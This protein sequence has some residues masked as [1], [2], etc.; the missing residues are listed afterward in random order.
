MYACEQQMCAVAA[1][2]GNSAATASASRA[3]SGHGVR[4]FHPDQHVRALVLDGLERANGPAEREP[5]PGVPGAHLPAPPGAAGLL[6]GQR[7][8][9]QI[10]HPGSS[11]GPLAFGTDED[12]GHLVE[13]QDRHRPGGIKRGNLCD[14]VRAFL[15]RQPGLRR[16]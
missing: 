10:E 13:G 11:A 6:G 4:E 8:A 3:A 1:A 12:R 14:R 16:M 15:I 2:T 7:H 5:G 9:G